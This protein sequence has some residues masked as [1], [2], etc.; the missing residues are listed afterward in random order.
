MLVYIRV[1]LTIKQQ[2]LQQTE[3]LLLCQSSTFKIP[4]G[5]AKTALNQEG[6]TAELDALK[7]E[8]TKQRHD[9]YVHFYAAYGKKKDPQT[10][11]WGH[12]IAQQKSE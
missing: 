4:T 5:S 8:S 3:R 1:K 10:P 9:D 11:K 12:I 2:T 6:K 7:Y